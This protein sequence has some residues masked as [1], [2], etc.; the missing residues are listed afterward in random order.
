MKTMARLPF[1]E[2]KKDIHNGY[3]YF[4][5]ES[6]WYGGDAHVILDGHNECV[7]FDFTQWND[8]RGDELDGTEDYRVFDLSFDEFMKSTY[9]E[10]CERCNYCLFY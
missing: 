1:G 3:N 2:V 10:I 4:E 5:Y 6:K 9:K 8:S 7:I